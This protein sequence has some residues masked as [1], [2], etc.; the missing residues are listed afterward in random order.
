MAEITIADVMNQNW[1]GAG[2][3]SYEVRMDGEVMDSQDRADAALAAFSGDEG[4][5]QDDGQQRQQQD[6]QQRVNGQQQ[7]GQEGQDAQRQQQAGQLTDEQLNADSRY[8]ELSAFRD[9]V[10]NALSEFAG[11]VGQDGKVNLKE[12]SLQLKDAAILYDIMQGRGT[13]SGLL[14]VMSK[15]SAW[16]DQQKQLI[17]T[18]LIQ[19]LTKGGYLKDG[20]AQGGKQQ[21]GK[22]NDPLTARLDKIESD[23]KTREQQA[24]QQ[25]EVSHQREVFDTKFLP[26]ITR[27]CKQKGIPQEDVNDYAMAIAG[28]VNGNKAVIGRIEKGNFVDVQK[29]FTERYNAEVQRLKRW[30]S[31]Q[32]KAADAKSKNPKIP[33]GGAPPAPNGS[34]KTVNVRDRDSRIAAASDML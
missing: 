31:A 24:A 13:P 21:D 1:G 27:L 34:A 19:W 2:F 17:A 25:R 10:S 7:D 5:Q 29:L 26:E 9:E 28:K 16:S 23:Q 20:Q 33:A 30:T 3:A 22:F 6:G 4:Q 14:E 11:L 32:T 8:Q 12:A 15:N 18:D